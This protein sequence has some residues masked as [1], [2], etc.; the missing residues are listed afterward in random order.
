MRGARE[1]FR[2]TRYLRSRSYAIVRRFWWHRHFCLCANAHIFAG[3][4]ARSGCATE[5][6]TTIGIFSGQLRNRIVPAGRKRPAAPQPFHGQPGSAT[7]APPFNRLK[8]ILRARRMKSAG[9]SEEGREKT[10]VDAHRK[11]QQPA[12]NSGAMRGRRFALYRFNA[13]FLK[14]QARAT[15]RCTSDTNSV[16]SI[17]NCARATEPRG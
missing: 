14:A 12:R 5:S 10:A 3:N 2:S 15:N 16:A 4:T 11:Q 1:T 17:V 13:R 9:G 8:R 6:R 7:R